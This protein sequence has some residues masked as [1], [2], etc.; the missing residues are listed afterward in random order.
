MRRIVAIAVLALAP[1]FAHAC[2]FATSTPPEGWFQW[3]SQLFGGEVT[4]VET[5]A[6][7]PVDIV[8]VKVAETF[9]GPE[10]ERATLTVRLSTRY[11]SNCKVE[12]PALGAQVLIGINPNGDAMLIPLSERFAELLRRNR[13]NK[14]GAG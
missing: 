1:A 8:I 13:K 2:L 5:D 4:A 12:K 6:A 11:W 7:K 9:K 14:P 3:S 10:V